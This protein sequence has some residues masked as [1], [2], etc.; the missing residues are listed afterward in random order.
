MSK[1]SETPPAIVAEREHQLRSF[2]R[3]GVE[4]AETL[5]EENRALRSEIEALRADG[6]RLRAQ[7]SSDD[8]IRDLIKTVEG[9]ETERRSL[10]ERSEN[11]E[12]R[13][14][15]RDTREAEVDQEISDLANLYVA[16][17]QLHTTLE[18]KRVLRHLSD[19]IGQLVGAES[20]AVFIA[21]D[22]KLHPIMVEGDRPVGVE[23]LGEGFVGSA[24]LAGIA[25]I[26]EDLSRQERPLAIIPF[27]VGNRSVG[28]AVLYSLLE[29][30][31][32][33]ASVDRELFELL[34]MH[35]GAALLSAT[36]YADQGS[37]DPVSAISEI[38]KHL[39]GD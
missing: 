17:F 6:A 13:A 12:A 28:G 4:Y 35:A 25:E 5:L 21:D 38:R 24:I 8:A 10:L 18:L 34:G 31:T 27:R 36:I 20:F 19:M 16:S 23:T 7:I 1:P 29:Q 37:P 2:L 22:Q 33:W 3:K 39:A 32:A 14:R 9:L 30:K 11:L 15:E 26:Q